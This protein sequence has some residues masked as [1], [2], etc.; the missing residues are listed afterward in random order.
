MAKGDSA[1]PT[2]RERVRV[3]PGYPALW[4]P[5]LRQESHR[6]ALSSEL[7]QSDST[8]QTHPIMETPPNRT[9]LARR[10]TSKSRVATTGYALTTELSHIRFRR[11]ELYG[12]VNSHLLD[13][14]TCEPV[15]CC[16][17]FIT[18]GHGSGGATVKASGAQTTK[19]TLSLPPCEHSYRARAPPAAS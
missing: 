6:A 10:N 18:T 13:Q 17:N 15:R 3:T 2:A 5:S 8:Y 14:T 9:P 1:I 16:V 12:L 11:A 19:Y 4:E 7:R